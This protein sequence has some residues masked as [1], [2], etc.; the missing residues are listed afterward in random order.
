MTS[1]IRNPLKAIQNRLDA[2]RQRAADKRTVADESAGIKD[3]IQALDRYLKGT[4]GQ[5]S[6]T[7]YMRGLS[8]HNTRISSRHGN[9]IDRRL[10]LFRNPEETRSLAV[11]RMLEKFVKELKG[12]TLS[13]WADAQVPIA[14]L[15]TPHLDSEYGQG[16]HMITPGL[17]DSVSALAGLMERAQALQPLPP[18]PP[19]SQGP[20]TPGAGGT[21]RPGAGAKDAYDI[22]SV[23]D[24]MSPRPTKQG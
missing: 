18:V 14:L 6:K 23:L 15:F 5:K 24:E 19:A 21:Q 20:T 1:P 16:K 13:T 17:R 2:S 12:M 11:D 9:W 8:G 22:F 3:R 4:N 7:L 10:T